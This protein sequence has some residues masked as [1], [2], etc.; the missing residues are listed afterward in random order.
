MNNDIKKNEN[1]EIRIRD[2]GESGEGIGRIDGFTVFVDKGVPGD[3]LKVKM[4][5]L[6]KNYGIGKIVEILEPSEDRVEP[7]CKYA[8]RCGGCQIQHIDY[9]AQL[10]LK[11]EKVVNVLERIG[12]LEDVVVKDT[13]GMDSPFRYRNKAQYPVGIYDGNAITGFYQRRSHRLVDIKD[14]LLQ[15]DSDERILNIIRDHVDKYKI[16][17]YNEE[18]GKGLLRHVLIRTSNATEEIMVVLVLKKKTLP[19]MDELVNKLIQEN[20]HIA[21]VIVNVNPKKTNVILGQECITIYGNETIM[22]KID[23]L[24]FNISPLS[25]FQVNPI[26]TEVLYKQALDYADLQ[27]DERVMDI[28][29]GIGTIS[30]FLAKKAK[31]VYGIE[32]V[33]PAIK[34]AIENAKNNNVD[35]AHFRVGKAEEVLPKL[36]EE[37]KEGDIIVVDPPR[38]GCEEIVLQTMA[39]MNPKKIVYVSCKP[40]TLARDL[41][42]LDE[43]GYKTVEVQPVDMF[44]HTGHVECVVK[45]VRK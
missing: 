11:K 4:I 8:N 1:Y 35:N 2:I 38:K 40:S 15:S 21:S 16:S 25:F 42:I 12:K 26:Q 19:A 7:P 6:K 13:I 27:G 3:L 45:V 30:L 37:G 36:Y 23:N 10:R 14:C 18:T 34:D 20:P 31:E 44:P 41:K 5:K 29:C 33:E 24:E 32:I 22:D 17:V 9:D 39:K 43:L 28:Y